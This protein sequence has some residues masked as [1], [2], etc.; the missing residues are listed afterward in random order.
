MS[1]R[2][3]YWSAVATTVPVLSLALV[4]EAR[5]ITKEWDRTVPVLYRTLQSVLWACILV[6]A[7]VAEYVTFKAL[8]E[9]S[10]P[11]WASGLC[12]L[13][14]SSLFGTL[15]ISPA[16]EFLVRG[17][18]EIWATILTLNP[19]KRLQMRRLRKQVANSRTEFSRLEQKT[20]DN[21][22][23][24]DAL[25]VQLDEIVVIVQ[26]KVAR[27]EI[28]ADQTAE[29][30]AGANQG[31][32]ELIAA[33]ADMTE[34]LGDLRATRRRIEGDVVKVDELQKDLKQ[35]I[36]RSREAVADD[37]LKSAAIGKGTSSRAKSLPEPEATDTRTEL[38]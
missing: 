9:E 10:T 24:I 34:N 6:G 30:T 8:A 1:V 31:R 14:I 33:K 36:A 25:M 35:I 28:S 12:R 15:I 21:I 5:A 16:L 19:R 11:T 22:G 29:I 13:V 17:P 2:V 38:G 23:E 32:A 37:L 27:D 4:L 3:E 7:A 26:E 18:A 20:M